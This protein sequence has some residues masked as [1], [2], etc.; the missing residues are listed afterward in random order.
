MTDPA[1]E[2]LQKVL[3]AAGIASRRVCEELIADG[4]VRVNGEWAPTGSGVDPEVDI[5]EGDGAVVS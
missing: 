1:G 2:K 4:R 3:A 5:F